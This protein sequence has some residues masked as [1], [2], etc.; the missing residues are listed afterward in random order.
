MYIE[1]IE[2]NKQRNK[3]E[4]DFKNELLMLREEIREF[5]EAHTVAERVDALVDTEYVWIGTRAKCSY[6]TYSIPSDIKE[7]IEASIDLM[8]EYLFEEL[9][10]NMLHILG[11]ARA[12]V[13]SANAEKGQ[14][15]DE[16]GKVTKEGFKR[17][18]TAEIAEMITEVIG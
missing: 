13:C 12:I 9:G 10:D 4:L 17:D 11:R 18:A 5:W 2:F 14:K 8:T 15:L 16:N 3:L 7:G 1:V 6:N